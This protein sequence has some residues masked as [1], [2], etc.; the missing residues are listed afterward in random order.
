MLWLLFSDVEFFSKSLSKYT[1]QH[2]IAQAIKEERSVG[3]LLL[4]A[5][6]LKEVLIPSPLKWLRV[7][8]ETCF[9][10]NLLKFT[11]FCYFAHQYPIFATYHAQEAVI[12]VVNSPLC[13]LP[14]ENSV[15]ARIRTIDSY[16]FAFY[17]AYVFNC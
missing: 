5:A 8:E 14:C 13:S 7:N 6:K 16:L 4:D 15:N 11:F 12:Y 3:L 1:N 10:Y 17:P 2:T 9:T